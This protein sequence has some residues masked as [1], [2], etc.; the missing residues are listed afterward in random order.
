ML[1]IDAECS[2]DIASNIA[3]CKLFMV[4]NRND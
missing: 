1:H 4:V 2:S 3:I